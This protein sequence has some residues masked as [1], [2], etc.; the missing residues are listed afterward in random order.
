M[1]QKWSQKLRKEWMDVGRIL[2][3]EEPE[4]ENIE[5]DRKL[6]KKETIYQMLLTWKQQNGKKQVTDF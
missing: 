3:L 6:G 2:K 1:L 5:S 4:L